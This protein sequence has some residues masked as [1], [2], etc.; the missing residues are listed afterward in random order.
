M[1]SNTTNTENYEA[2]INTIRTW[3]VAQRFRLLQ[4]VLVTLTPEVAPSTQRQPT[5]SHALGLLATHHPAPSDKEIAAW[6]D[7]RRQERYGL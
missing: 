3:S 7:E 5:L 1:E 4:D 6:L 2:V